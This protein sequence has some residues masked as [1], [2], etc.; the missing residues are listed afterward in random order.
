MNAETYEILALAARYW[1]IALAA[2]VV[3]RGWRSAVRDNRKAKLLRDWAGGAGCVG[4]LVVL[5]DGQKSKKKTLRGARFA[6]PEEGLIG[7]GG[8]ADIRIHHPDVRRRH[9]RFVYEPGRLVL[10][11][12]GRAKAE[13]PVAP[14]G[15]QTL[16][17]GDRLTIGRLKLLMVFYDVQDAAA[18]QSAAVVSGKKSGKKEF[19]EAY[20]ENFWE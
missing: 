20:E 3:I 15:R 12:A 11:N 9:I 14:D 1:F 4:E 5:D 2:L 13:C 10:V 16:R 19:E 17:D 8:M 7:S 6:V 18:A